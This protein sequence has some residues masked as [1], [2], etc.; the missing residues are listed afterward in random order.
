MQAKE[1]ECPGMKK[2][3][4]GDG[5]CVGNFA[6]FSTGICGMMGRELLKVCM[7]CLALSNCPGRTLKMQLP[8][9]GT[10]HARCYVVAGKM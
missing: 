3:L 7:M 1:K 5:E 2:D 10:F 6:S 4:V 8:K 9:A